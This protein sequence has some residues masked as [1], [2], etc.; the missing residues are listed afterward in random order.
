MGELASSASPKSSSSSVGAIGTA[1]T[2][3]V[4][5]STMGVTDDATVAAES[6]FELAASLFLIGAKTQD[7][8]PIQ[9]DRLVLQLLDRSSAMDDSEPQGRLF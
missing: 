5:R 9:F 6:A 1:L 2:T 4:L 3:G 8:L 7:Q